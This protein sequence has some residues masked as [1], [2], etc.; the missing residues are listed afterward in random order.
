[1]IGNGFAAPFAKFS[2]ATCDFVLGDFHKWSL[3]PVIE[4][5]IEQ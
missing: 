2:V 5:G 4:S 3:Y 1:M